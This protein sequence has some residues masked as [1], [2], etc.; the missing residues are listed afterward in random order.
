[1]IFFALGRLVFPLNRI[2]VTVFVIVLKVEIKVDIVVIVDSFNVFAQLRIRGLQAGYSIFG[3]IL[4]IIHK[5]S[6]LVIDQLAKR[7]AQPLISRS[8]RFRL[9]E[10]DYVL[11]RRFFGRWN[12]LFF[13]FSFF[14][15]LLV[16]LDISF[17]GILNLR[18][19]VH[20]FFLLLGSAIEQR[21][22]TL[23]IKS[24]LEQP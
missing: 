17:E 5:A 4:Q 13:D 15:D 8:D 16:S 24:D 3:K 22:H 10:F 6:A 21:N 19:D 18:F 7:L 12:L 1:V 14:I 23:V 20:E 9:L 2:C 11:L